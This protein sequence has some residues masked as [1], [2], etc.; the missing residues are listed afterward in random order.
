MGLHLNPSPAAESFLALGEL[1]LFLKW[2]SLPPQGN[3][4]VLVRPWSNV[5]CPL[6][7]GLVSSS[8]CRPSP[9]RSGSPAGPSWE[10]SPGQAEGRDEWGA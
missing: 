3:G 5:K 7:L 8:P 6:P 2:R 1:S 4:R 9:N 10:L